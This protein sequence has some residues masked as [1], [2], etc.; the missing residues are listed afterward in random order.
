MDQSAF[1]NHVYLSVVNR[2]LVRHDENGRQKERF[3][4]ILAIINNS[5][6]HWRYYRPRDKGLIIS[7]NLLCFSGVAPGYTPEVPPALLDHGV[8]APMYK[9]R[10]ATVPLDPGLGLVISLGRRDLGVLGSM[11]AV[12]DMRL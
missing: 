11:A 1:L 6:T 8:G 12:A 4:P 9:M 5:S 7:D 10:R 3:N 2:W